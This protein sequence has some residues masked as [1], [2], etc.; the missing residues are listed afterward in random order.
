MKAFKVAEIK[1]KRSKRRGSGETHGVV[2]INIVRQN[3][4]E[5]VYFLMGKE[6]TL[7]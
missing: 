4:R 5:I 2:A 3:H 6:Y 7:K 1:H